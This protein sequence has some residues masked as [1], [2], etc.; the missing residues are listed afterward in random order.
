[1]YDV[2]LD[3]HSEMQ[4]PVWGLEPT[5]NVACEVCLRLFRRER[6]KKRHK[7]SGNGRNLYMFKRYGE[8]QCVSV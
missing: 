7:C 2:G 8:D 4:A 6:D 1:M 5:D 3:S